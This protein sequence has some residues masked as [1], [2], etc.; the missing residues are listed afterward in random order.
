MREIKG[1][2]KTSRKIKGTSKNI[3]SPMRMRKKYDRRP[4]IKPRAA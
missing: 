1:T 4:I 3:F 2:L